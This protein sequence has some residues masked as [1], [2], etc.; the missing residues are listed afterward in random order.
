MKKLLIFHPTIAPYRI[1]FF[2]SL[3]EAFETR[4][5]LLYRNLKSQKFDYAK[6]EKQFVYT[7]EYLK[8]GLKIGGRRLYF[9]Y[10]K[11]LCQFKPDSDY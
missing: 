11:H 9:G 2:N 7:P 4:V 5:C 10:W 6:I 8:E 1:D 3:Y